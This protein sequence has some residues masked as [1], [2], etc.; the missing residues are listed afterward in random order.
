[1]TSLTG[2]NVIQVSGVAFNT[3]PPGQLEKYALTVHFLLYST[4]KVGQLKGT[5]SACAELPKLI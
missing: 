5:Y 1:M 4:I 3:F 2:V